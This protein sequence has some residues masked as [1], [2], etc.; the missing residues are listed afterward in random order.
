[1]DIVNAIK[2]ET[3]LPTADTAFANPQKLPFVVILDKTEA[4]GDDYTVR[5]INHDLAV[6]FYA[7]R[8]DKGNEI[9][10]ET[11]FKKQNWK[12]TKERTWL[13]DEKCFET[14]YLMNFKERV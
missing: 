8:I 4:D 14:I 2:K 3:Q 6:E 13:P 7:E 5:I 12:Y 1:M 11:F 9:K 10:L